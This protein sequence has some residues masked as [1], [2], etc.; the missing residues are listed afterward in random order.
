MVMKTK[1][2]KEMMAALEQA[3]ARV[4]G[5]TDQFYGSKNENNGI[6]VAAD[7]NPE[8]FDYYSERWMDTFGVD[9]KLNKLVE[10]NGWYFEWYDPGTM[11]VWEN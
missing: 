3:G 4:C 2:I 5:T 10:D 11:M 7:S 6:W 1:D 9:P 8:L